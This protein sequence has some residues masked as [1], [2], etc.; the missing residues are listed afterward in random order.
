MRLLHLKSWSEFH[1]AVS[2]VQQERHCAKRILKAPLYRGLADS[3][4][5]LETTLERL[6]ASEG[7]EP[8]S[9]LLMYYHAV[10]RSQTAIE[11]FSGNRWDGLPEPPQFRNEIREDYGWLDQ[12]MFRHTRI[13][14]YLVYLRHHS[15]PSPLLDWTISPYVAAFFAFDTPHRGARCVCVYALMQDTFHGGAS[16]AH[17]FVIG[18]Y[19]RTDRRHFLQQCRY[20]MCVGVDLGNHD[21]R[22]VPHEAGLE[23]ALGPEGKLLK[24]TVPVGDRTAALKELEQMNINAFSLFG[25]EDSLVRTV[26]R[27]EML[28][29]EQC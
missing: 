3:R 4:W 28:F 8:I 18:P 16:D 22:F 6:H 10:S 23:G 14:E 19:M 13:F 15:F 20:T 29:R 25:S 27:R 12:F 7:C 24:I 5:K 26:G 1:E 11:S 17:L 21:Y 9:S 2:R